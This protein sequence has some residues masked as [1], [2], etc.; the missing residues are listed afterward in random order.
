M[1]LAKPTQT[2]APRAALGLSLIL[3]P[4]MG[5]GAQPGVMSPDPPP[6]VEA[7]PPAARTSLATTSG[8]RPR[9]RPIRKRPADSTRAQVKIKRKRKARVSPPLA[10]PA[11]T[12]AAAAAT[13]AVASAAAA[14]PDTA[15]DLSTISGGRHL[16]RLHPVLRARAIA[17]YTAAAERGIKLTF[18]SG[19]RPFRPTSAK[20]RK[21]RASWHA[22]GMA[23]DVNLADRRNMKD[24]LA[25]FDRDKRRWQAVGRIAESLGLTW[26]LQW[27]RHEVFHFEWHPGMPDAI[28][29]PTLKTL[30]GDTGPSGQAIE[31]TWWRFRTAEGERGHHH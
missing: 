17:L 13:V 23:F 2:R 8:P 1:R 7:A 14:V 24:A 22:F 9:K 31:K 11:A 5:C 18:I 28:R 6:M 26:G 29:R 19:H 3:M 10:A 15:V 30:L 25:H 20:A 16:E 12:P 21:G 27:G 4:L